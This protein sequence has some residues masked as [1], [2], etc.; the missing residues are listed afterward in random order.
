MNSIRLRQY[1]QLAK[2]G[3][4]YGNLLTAAAAFAFS[5]HH[6]THAPLSVALSVLFVATLIGLGLSIAAGCVI[7]NVIERDIDAR[8]E[9]TKNRSLPMK[10]ISVRSALIYACLLGI[11]GFTILYFFT[12][13]YAL[14]ATV[15]GVVVYIAIYTPSKQL[16]A[17]STI[18]GAFA[19]AVPPVVGYVAVSPVHDANA[20]LLFLILMSWQMPHFF[21]IS[22]YR[23]DEYKNAGLPVMP[24]RIGRIKT[25]ILMVLHAILFAAATLI[26]GLMNQLS[27]FYLIP[28]AIVSL[29]WIGFSMAGFW[30][31]DTAH[32]ARKTFL[33][34]LVVLLLFSA[35]LAFA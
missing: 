16:T 9:R 3:I 24:I 4:I 14:L 26:F 30:S 12:T 7:N 15:F 33:F 31:T 2:P 1:Y 25:Q 6:Q 34:S 22:L 32:W 17:H 29:V 21:A 35:L 18:L 19:G 10:E 28:M 8:M 23:T 27:L 11:A 13:L 5:V 20:L